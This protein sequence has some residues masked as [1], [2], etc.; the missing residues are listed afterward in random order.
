MRSKESNKERLGV[1]DAKVA[2]LLCFVIE[3]DCI[4]YPLLCNKLPPNLAS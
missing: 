4:S 1:F 2:L 3:I